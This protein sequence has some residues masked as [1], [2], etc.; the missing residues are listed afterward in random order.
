M[1]LIPWV[2]KEACDADY[3]WPKVVIWDSLDCTLFGRV[4][5]TLKFYY[6]TS[7]TF[8]LSIFFLLRLRWM[9]LLLLQLLIFGRQCWSIQ[10]FPLLLGH[11]WEPRRRQHRRCYLALH[12]PK[13]HVSMPKFEAAAGECALSFLLSNA[14]LQRTMSAEHLP[15]P[16]SL[17]TICDD[18][19]MGVQ[20]CNEC[21]VN[22]G[23]VVLV[24]H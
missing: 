17:N 2:S 12:A 1:G 14:L 13:M 18:P 24:L 21:C 10:D 20:L 16:Y 4:Q 11:P 15:S 6:H 3:F 23:A 5:S 9:L 7:S 22:I 19:H 8:V